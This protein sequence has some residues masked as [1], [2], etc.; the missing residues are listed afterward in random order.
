MADSAMLAL[1]MEEALV[2]YDW[3]ARI[4]DSEA[5]AVESVEQRALWDL[6][7]QLESRLPMIFDAD[8]SE[9]VREARDT[10]GQNGEP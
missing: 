3:I 4:N 5:Q 9:R 2:L 8:Y 10:I 7:S 1:S 6:E